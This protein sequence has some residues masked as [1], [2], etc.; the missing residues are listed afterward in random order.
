MTVL[1]QAVRQSNEKLRLL[2]PKLKEL[3]KK[4]FAV[5]AHSQ[6]TRFKLIEAANLLKMQN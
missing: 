5:N 6:D 3:Q 1:T 4:L 2:R